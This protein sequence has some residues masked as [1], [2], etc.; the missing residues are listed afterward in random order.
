MKFPN[1]SDNLRFNGRI[2][3][4][5]LREISRSSS[6]SEASVGVVL[7]YQDDVIKNDAFLNV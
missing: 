6:K 4:T 3:C 2:N 1:D 5:V 7:S